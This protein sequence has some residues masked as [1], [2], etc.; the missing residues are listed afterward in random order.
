LRA[1]RPASY[2]GSK[3]SWIALA[4]VACGS[5]VAPARRSHVESARVETVEERAP[6]EPSAQPAIESDGSRLPRR[7][8]PRAR[9]SG[10]GTVRRCG[11]RVPR[12]SHPR[13]C[14]RAPA[15][16]AGVEPVNEVDG[17]HLYLELRDAR[18]LLTRD[19]ESTVLGVPPLLGDYPL[20]ELLRRRD[21]A[22]PDSVDPIDLCLGCA[23]F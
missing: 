20:T 7:G 13:S 11:R 15:L 12:S 19:P 2:D 3:V 1:R 6:A 5:D 22:W 8:A 23:T 4:L 21:L 10:G 16:L 17:Y 14:E 18:A 9:G